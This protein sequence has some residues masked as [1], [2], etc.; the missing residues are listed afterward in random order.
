VLKEGWEGG[1][2]QMPSTGG[3]VGA[4]LFQSVLGIQPDPAGPGFKKF[5][6][7][8]QP[9]VATGLTS[10]NGYYDSIYG[11]ITSTWK[12]ERGYF[13]LHAVVPVNTTATIF[14]PTAAATSVTESLRPGAAAAQ[15]PG[16][17]YL[18]MS[19]N[20]AVYQVE[21]GQYNFTSLLPIQRTQP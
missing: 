6:L 10:A 2:A 19:G 7:A 8:P 1:N 12:V 14:I 13:A 21:S 15:S 5:I 4:W 11:R 20:A 3:S 9:D 18:G 16:V 17:K